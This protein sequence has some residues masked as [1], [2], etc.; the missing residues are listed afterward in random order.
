MSKRDYYEVLGVEKGASE[1]ELKKAYRRLAMKYHPDRNPDDENAEEKFK[2]ATE[3][4]EV[5]TDANKRAA[6]DQYGH[7]GV[8]PSMG[9]G[10]G[11]FGGG[12]ANFSDIFGD[13]FGDIFG[14]GGGRGRS[15]VQRGSDLRYTLE[16]DLEE[17]VRG[18]T[19][20]IR[21]P[22]LVA[23]ETCDGSGAKKGTTPT[24]CTTCGGH[25]Q[26][27]MQQGFFSVQQ[28]CPR[29]HGTGKMITDPCK[30][31]HGNGRVEKQKNLSVKVPAGV[32]T[33]DRI[34]LAGEGEA[35]VNGGPAGDLYVVVSV[36]EH[37]IF[38]RDGKNLYCEVPISFVDAA[39]GG[40]LE[41]PTLDGRVK[42]KIPEGAQ[43]GKLFRLR[44]KGVTPVRGGSAG[45]LLCRVVVETPVN[46]TKRQ[47]ELLEELRQTLEAEGSSQSPRAKSW[48]DGVKNFFEDMKF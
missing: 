12:G 25:G 33:G 17:A 32:D 42:L 15:S 40:E 37:K 2:E 9:G 24:T 4:Y 43:T 5:L 3:A 39:L 45:D 14:G 44:G 10:A 11:G 27:R 19:V 46:L 30:D 29:C 23:C 35:G 18:T 13:V 41:V 16:L 36:R 20:T 26:V 34:R 22:T 28:T 31:C 7:A 38:Q 8:D 6:Y 1:A 47:R 48:F 21:V